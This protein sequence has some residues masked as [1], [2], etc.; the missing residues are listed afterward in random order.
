[1]IKPA[2]TRGVI[3]SGH[4]EVEL[5]PSD[6]EK[7]AGFFEEKEYGRVY[8]L[9]EEGIKLDFISRYVAPS[10]SFF[11]LVF[12]S[13]TNQSSVHAKRRAASRL[14]SPY[15]VPSIPA[16][17]SAPSAPVPFSKRTL[18][19]QQAVLNL[20]Y[21]ATQADGAD[22]DSTNVLINALIS[23]ASP[24]V[25]DLVARGSVSGA[26]GRKMSKV[27]LAALRAMR[28]WLGAIVERAEG[29]GEGMEIDGEGEVKLEQEQEQGLESGSEAGRK[30]KREPAEDE[31][32]EEN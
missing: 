28:G 11:S 17:P 20:E 4:I 30:R 25:I 19:D 13:V 2:I 8:K 3:N 24:A 7:D 16:L 10:T 9:P 6:D 27:E 14:Q 22:A 29:E 26:V 23:E 12:N 15:S 18:D 21:L 32:V 1:M 31:G 5:T